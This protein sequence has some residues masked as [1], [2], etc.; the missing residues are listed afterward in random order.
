MG[1][2]LRLT[3]LTTTF[4]AL[5]S[6]VLAQGPTLTI[7][8]AVARA[9]E[10]NPAARSAAAG[11]DEARARA[12]EA[13]SGYLPRVDAFEGW[14][15]GD[16]PVF[17]FSSS[18]AQRRF[19]ADQFAIDF[20]NNPGALS[21]HR[22]AVTIEQTLF[23]GGLAARVRGAR[24]G[25]DLAA[26]ARARV[27]ADLRLAV[28]TAFSAAAAADARHA[29]ARTALETATEDLR[30]TEARRDVGLETEANVLALRVHAADAEARL[31]RA[32][33]DEA[34]ARAELS[35]LM[36]EPLDA[37]FELAPL[38]PG[39]VPL[40]GDL[41]TL[42]ARALA[43]RPEVLETAKRRTQAAASRAAARGGLMPRVI[44]QGGLEANGRSFGERASAWA[45]A[46]EL[47]WTV[48][49]G[50]ANLAQLKAA[51]AAEAR[52]EADEES[53]RTAVLLDVRKAYAAHRAAV[54]REVTIR[55]MVEQATESH[56]IIRDRYDAGLA[57]ATDLLRAA[58]TV[59]Q[60]EAD[61]IAALA[62]LHTSAASLARA[63]GA[64]G[65][66]P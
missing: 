24:A 14:Q 51:A 5:A 11:E 63:S 2:M 53:V 57:S 50:G 25:V 60:A 8:D 59:Q 32:E 26:L 4:L 64:S 20:L 36:R 34:V 7:D 49:N 27:R 38:Q 61:R 15:R 65:L 48:F 52:A 33:A 42:E 19:T 28:V 39:A 30:R 43:E 3:S 6:A 13:T 12:R 54:A 66:Q 56:R 45:G 16:H 55:R 41:P 37:S 58:T 22:A 35:A 44:A 17:V 29:A 10:R 18:L 1:N 46:L 21:N 62:D 31:V 47:R 40:A 9:I 23:D